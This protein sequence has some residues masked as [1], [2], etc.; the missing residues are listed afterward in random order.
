MMQIV[1]GTITRNL[2]RAG[3]VLL[4]MMLCATLAMAQLDTSLSQPLDSDL[5]GLDSSVAPIPSDSIEPGA[6]NLQTPDEHVLP[7]DAI[8]ASVIATPMSPAVTQYDTTTRMPFQLDTSIRDASIITG[9]HTQTPVNEVEVITRIQSRLGSSSALQTSTSQLNPFSTSTASS[10]QGKPALNSLDP[11]S[12]IAAPSSSWRTG[13]LGSQMA[14]D[15]MPPPA[16]P[17][18][19]LKLVGEDT[20]KK[21]QD[22]L[23]PGNK[24]TGK[25]GSSDSNDSR[26]SSNASQDTNQVQDS[27]RSPLEAV[28]ASSGSSQEAA[29]NRA[30]P[31]RPMDQGNFLNPDI[32]LAT[33][34]SAAASPYQSSA[35]SNF[36]N[37]R[38]NPISGRTLRS[39][40]A[41]T[42]NVDASL[43]RDEKRLLKHNMT[44][45][46][47]RTKKWHNPLLQ[48]MED[49]ANA[50][51]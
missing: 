15:P 13:I 38:T 1:T 41:S 24:E 48:Q 32:T 8:G 27:S 34:R 23:L 40:K 18:P 47:K 11:T 44:D 17:P 49:N 3:C 46:P 28:D 9:L 51:Q 31:F 25:A 39:D 22:A 16:E 35:Q 42:N 45:Q 36:A 43:T 33:A 6:N 4:G 19:P 37:S 21:L 29:T 10:S 50:D 12:G 2:L 30:S 7:Y 20:S 5:G 14:I 26:D